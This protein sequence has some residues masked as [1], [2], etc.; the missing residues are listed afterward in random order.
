M[1]KDTIAKGLVITGSLVTASATSAEAVSILDLFKDSESNFIRKIF[2]LDEIENNNKTSKESTPTIV[3]NDTT[4][5][6]TLNEGETVPNLADNPDGYETIIVKTAGNKELTIKDFKNLNKS[7]IPNI[8]LS[9]AKAEN[10][11]DKAFKDNEHL[12]SFKFPKDVL[13]ISAEAF[14][15]CSKL[16]G[17]LIIPDTVTTIEDSA[18]SG[19]RKLTG[20]L[21]IP[22]SVTYLGSSAFSNCSG[23]NGSLTLSEN[24]LIINE[25]TFNGCMG[26]VGTLTIPESITEIQKNAFNYCSKLEGD[27]TIP[28][29]VTSIGDSAFAYC[30][31]FNGNLTIGKSVETIGASAFNNCSRLIGNLFIPDSTISIGASAFNGC[32]SL[33]G[34]IKLPSSLTII[35]NSVFAGC[36]N[37][38]GDLLIPNSITSI[39]NDAFKNCK[40]LTGD[41]LIPNSVNSIGSGAFYGCYGFDGELTISNSISVINK[42]TFYGCDSLVGNL[43][44]PSTVTSIG[45]GAFYECNGF[46]GNLVIPNTVKDI[47]KEAFYKCTGLTGDLIIPEIVT[48]IG[49][50]AFYGCLGFKGELS[51]GDAVEYIGNSAFGECRSLTGTLKIP[52]ATTFIGSQA[53][54]NC[55]GFTGNVFIPKAVEE[56][57]TVAFLGM[58]N[59]EFIMGIDESFEESNY[60]EDMI[61]GL[62]DYL[63]PD[64]LHIEAPYEFNIS[65][66]W[67][68][69]I[70]SDYIKKPVLTKTNNYVLLSIPT[71]YTETNIKVLR[72]DVAYKLPEINENL[73]YKFQ[74]KG[75]YDVTLTTDLGTTSNISFDIDTPIKNSNIVYD[76]TGILTINNDT[77]KDNVRFEYR[78]NEGDWFEYTAPFILES[79]KKDVT[80][81]V[82]VIIDDNIDDAYVLEENIELV[83]AT[84]DA[85][86][87][88]IGIGKKFS[89]LTGV[90]ALDI[91]GTDISTSIEVISNNVDT[92]LPGDYKVTYKVI[93]KNKYAV[94]KT[95]NVKVM[96]PTIN[97]SDK[98]IYVGSR[99]NELE[100]VSA[101]D[102]TGK[103]ITSQIKVVENKV[104][105]NIEG[106][107]PVIY[108]V[109]E[110]DMTITKTIFVTV[111]K[112]PNS[113]NGNTENNKPDSGDSENNSS[114][115][116]VNIK[117]LSVN[118]NSSFN[119]LSGITILDSTGKNI[120]SEVNIKVLYN[121]VD[122]SKVGVYKVAYEFSYKGE[123]S[124]KEVEVTVVEAPANGGSSTGGSN[125][126]SNSNSTVNGTNKPQTS[127]TSLVVPTGVTVISTAGLFIVNRKKK[128]NNKK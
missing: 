49:D 107:Y 114:N 65:N 76:N 45:E 33:N 69:D 30:S 120:T 83:T 58:N 23:L 3:V 92:K 79:E 16:E 125:T 123:V 87:I 118:L 74:T 93:G 91:D 47:K 127:D 27:I 66:T 84:I 119:P 18:Y 110:N 113:N 14:S 116:T 104:N 82:K 67:L 15:G 90:N 59:V 102:S 70:D 31:G 78:V 43:I 122:T 50:K 10:I 13:V 54:I 109:T 20:D 62:I 112:N 98:T 4:L 77:N 85:S 8:D 48:S 7:L 25:Y 26:I 57:G 46:E 37:L 32:S 124:T 68:K 75:A 1:K 94:T 111:V 38:K 24:M 52:S 97:A 60:R 34:K 41:L 6:I 72:N 99:F 39:G 71:P 56:I 86:D 19:C 55:N 22:N 101:I 121:H 51:M 95:I 103:N 100:G 105:T 89:E 5:E 61:I 53:F 17:Q 28:N 40:K 11:P 63:T 35:E 21:T 96:A 44:I 80:L 126:N 117:N 73:E 81:E 12:V 9:G 88:E 2:S 42:Q 108:S 128:D 29:S 115:I 64:K 106:I 36:S